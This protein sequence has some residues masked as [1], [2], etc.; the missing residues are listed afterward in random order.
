MARLAK[1]LCTALILVLICGFTCKE[2]DLTLLVLTDVNNT[3]SFSKFNIVEHDGILIGHN[4]D[5]YTVKD[6]LYRIQGSSN[7]KYYHHNILIKN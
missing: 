5:E 6:G 3:D 1:A 7:D 4:M 2:N